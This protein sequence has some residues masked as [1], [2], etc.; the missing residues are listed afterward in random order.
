M[1]TWGRGGSRV[2]GA[3]GTFGDASGATG[4]RG[5]AWSTRVAPP[6]HD[7]GHADEYPPCRGGGDGGRA[8]PPMPRS[9]A[10]VASVVPPPPPPP[11]L[12]PPRQA[13]VPADRRSANDAATAFPL[14]RQRI[15]APP[16]TVVIADLKHTRPPSPSPPPLPPGFEMV[17]DSVAPPCVSAACTADAA[18]T[19]TFAAASAPPARVGLTTAAGLLSVLEGASTSSSGSPRTST[20]ARSSPASLPLTM[21]SARTI[22]GDLM[23]TLFAPAVSARR[24]QLGSARSTLAAGAAGSLTA[25]PT[26]A[27]LLREGTGSSVLWGDAMVPPPLP[28]SAAPPATRG[29]FGAATAATRGGGALPVIREPEREPESTPVP[30][31]A[32]GPPFPTGAGGLLPA[33]AALVPPPPAMPS[34]PPQY[35]WVVMPNGQPAYLPMSYDMPAPPLPPPPPPAATP[36]PSYHLS[37][38]AAPWMPP[39]AAANAA[40]AV[41]A[42]AAS[43]D[44]LMPFGF[45]PM[46]PPPP[47]V[48]YNINI[49]M[50]GAGASY[51]DALV[52]SG[53]GGGGGGGGGGPLGALSTG[54]TELLGVLGDAALPP[55]RGGGGGGVAWDDSVPSGRHGGAYASRPRPSGGYAYKGSGG[56]W[57]D[58]GPGGGRP[59]QQA[60]GRNHHQ[61]GDV[62]SSW[63]P[64]VPSPPAPVPAAFVAAAAA[65]AAPVVAEVPSPPALLCD[66]VLRRDVAEV[67]RLLA[68]GASPEEVD[69]KGRTPLMIAALMGQVEA[70][71]ALLAARAVLDRRGGGEGWSALYFAADA[72]AVEA[73]RTLVRAG[74]DLRTCNKFAA[75]PLSAAACAG[76]DAVVEVL[77]GAGADK[78]S[79]STHHYTPLARAAAHGRTAVVR[80]LLAAGANRYAAN[81]SGRLPFQLALES[82]VVDCIVALAADARDVATIVEWLEHRRAMPADRG[83][84]GQLRATSTALTVLA[85]ASRP[86]WQLPPPR[87]WRRRPDDADVPMHA[88]MFHHVRCDVPCALP[89]RVLCVPYLRAPA[90]T[91]SPCLPCLRPFCACVPFVPC[92][93]GRALRHPACPTGTCLACG[94]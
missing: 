69:T 84:A 36:A 81:K 24:Q 16:P 83:D 73:V 93:A 37:P 26:A 13:T 70:I 64:P 58:D 10:A 94:A 75:T 90:Y 87:T 41:A 8:P 55:R 50:H 91:A 35:A 49:H 82:G 25:S 3:G 86:P 38:D 43:F 5:W 62:G 31:F 23:E 54:L 67:T 21:C 89:A 4:A 42:P 40:A 15:V 27:E 92:L 60:G 7:G 6:S 28:V 12:P 45:T 66:A 33:A 76:H 2:A 74:A 51:D 77:L 72:G 32:A 22:G 17:A 78:E 80:R 61:G 11:P 53:S 68:D 63:R 57:V 88:C 14:L 71:E 56:G 79:R 34:A 19:T 52:A 44:A 65:A 1:K 9:Y 47:P 85:A 20:T 30:A 46:P 59:R 18:A 39:S 29:A 48:T